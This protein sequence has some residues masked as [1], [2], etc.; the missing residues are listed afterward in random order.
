MAHGIRELAAND[1]DYP[2]ALPEL[3]PLDVLRI[4]VSEELS[5]ISGVS[6]ELIFSSLETSNTLQKGDLLLATPKL[7][8]KG[9]K[10]NELATGW[11][12]QV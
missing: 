5:R 2:G 7:R 8:V 10:P 3:K 11:A 1:G 9:V 4:A 6:K 12:A